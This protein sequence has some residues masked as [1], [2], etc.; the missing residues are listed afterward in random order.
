[1][2]REP[3]LKRIAAL[4]KIPCSTLITSGINSRFQ[5]LFQTWGQITHAFL[6]LAPLCHCWHRSTCMPNPCRQRSFWARIKLSKQNYS[7]PVARS[8]F[9]L[10][11]SILSQILSIRFYLLRLCCSFQNLKIIFSGSSHYSIFKELRRCFSTPASLFSKLRF[12]YQ[13]QRGFNL[14]PFFDLSN[15]FLIFFKS[16]FS[17]ASFKLSS[18]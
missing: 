3:L 5:E 16:F 9:V 6:T 15:Q 17:T 10:Q 14:A 11:D 1:M 13:A 2:G 18:F 12:A 8:C 7:K 4:I